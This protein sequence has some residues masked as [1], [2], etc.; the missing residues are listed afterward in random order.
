MLKLY[1]GEGGHST[2][3]QPPPGGCVLKHMGGITY[4]FVYLA[5]ASGRLCVETG[6]V[7]KMVLALRRSRLRAAVC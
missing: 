5:A 4:R 3:E 1:D 7:A 2:L 6:D